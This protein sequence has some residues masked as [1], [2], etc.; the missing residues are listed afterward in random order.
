VAGAS[1]VLKEGQV[2]FK[3]GDAPDGM[4]LIR[5]GE[6]RIYL[7]QDG[8][9]VTL[10]NVA[11]GSMIGEMGLFDK[12]ARSASVKAVTP[13]EVT[14]ISMDDFNR[15]MKQ[16]P[17]WFVGL[18]SA[19]SG[20]LR[21]TN[22]RLQ[23]IEN[24]GSSGEKP[25]QHV[26]RYLNILML[27]WAKDGTKEGRDYILPKKDSEEVMINLFDEDPIKLKQFFEILVNLEYFQT[28][29]DSYNNVVFATPNKGHLTVLAKFVSDYAKVCGD[30][31]KCL[32]DPAL[33]MLGVLQKLTEDNPYDGFS[34]SVNDLIKE[35]KRQGLSTHNW[36]KAIIAFKNAGDGVKL[37][38]VSDGVGLRTNKKE[39]TAFAKNH[40]TLAA[41]V[42]GNL[43]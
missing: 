9:E 28:K 14:H 21:D 4:Y 3:A 26:S 12:Q 8:K 25:F 42:K 7:E 16:I 2:L 38:K 43:A 22:A 34:A 20:R 31:S 32:P 11:A 30:K 13:T 18:M 40:A 33:M 15:L 6:L 27:L 17:K 39:I 36:D 5:K 29:K 19:L 1:K 24:G 23:R 37:V 10:A 35:G 41:F